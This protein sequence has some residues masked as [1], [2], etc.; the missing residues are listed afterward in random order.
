MDLTL[1]DGEEL[2]SVTFIQDYLQLDFNGPGFTFFHWPEVFIPEGTSLAEGSYAQGDP[3]YRDA[4]CSQIGEPVEA[5]SFEEYVAIEIK[6]QTGA[7]FRVSLRE[8]DYEGPEAGHFVSG[9]QGD[10]LVV[11]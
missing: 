2:S 7:I 6:F 10:S 8:E 3:G 9:I 5:S 1:L 11:F 4:V